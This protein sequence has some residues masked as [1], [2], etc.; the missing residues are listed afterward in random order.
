MN[1]SIHIRH[2]RALRQQGKTLNLSAAD[3]L[4]FIASDYLARISIPE[5]TWLIQMDGYTIPLRSNGTDARILT[6]V[7][8]DAYRLESSSPVRRILDLG[9]NI[10]LSALYFHRAYPDASIACVEASPKNAE[11]L[12]RAVSLNRLPAR[13][14]QAAI[15]VD[16]GTATFWDTKDPSCST[17]IQDQRAASA[18]QLTV[19]QLTVESVMDQMGWDALDL[20]KIDIEG[21][22]RFLLKSN[23]EWL[24]KTTAIVG[25]IHEGYTFDELCSDL[26]PFGFSV[27]ERSRNEIH[28]MV[29][30]VAARPSA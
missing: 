1:P 7:F 5:H 3:T 2:I 14:I 4:K 28:G 10:G 15:G 24:G 6:E 18:A 20:V 12:A 25:E 23:V 30:F 19:K 13:I 29:N 26:R 9:A 21:Y 17:L 16:N 11:L 8:G 27:A 22:E